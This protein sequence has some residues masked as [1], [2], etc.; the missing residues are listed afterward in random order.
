MRNGR[1]VA[2]H[3]PMGFTFLQS[4]LLMREASSM[5]SAFLSLTSSPSSCDARG[6]SSVRR[7]HLATGCSRS[8]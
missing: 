6:S 1:L 5:K 2:T 8:S 7:R 4:S 3:F